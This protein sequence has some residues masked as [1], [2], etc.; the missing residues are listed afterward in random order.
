MAI[1]VEQ[2]FYGKDITLSNAFNALV[3]SSTNITEPKFKFVFDIYIDDVKQVRVR[4]SPNPSNR[5]VISLRE[6]LRSFVH[7]T[8]YNGANYIDDYAT[9]T[10]VNPND[11]TVRR[12][13]IEIFESYAPTADANPVIVGSATTIDDKA[14]MLGALQYS[15]GL[16]FDTDIYLM[17]SNARKGDFLTAA[18]EVE[19]NK[20]IY[21]TDEDTGVLAGLTF[22]PSYTTVQNFGTFHVDYYEADG[23]AL[24]ANTISVTGIQSDIATPSEVMRFYQCYPKNL[25]ELFT[26][27]LDPNNGANAGWKYYE[28]YIKNSADTQV[29][30][31]VVRFEK[32]N[33]T[34]FQNVRLRFLNNLGGWDYLNFTLN[35]Q[36][37]FNADRFDYK[38]LLG[39]YSDTLFSFGQSDRGD[40]ISNVETVER[41]QVQS[42]IYPEAYNSVFRELLSSREVY[43]MDGVI[44]RPVVIEDNSKQMI[45]RIDQEMIRYSFRIVYSNQILSA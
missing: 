28:V 2:N 8:K 3:V 7:P 29:L 11:N 13:K 39:N 4:R 20:T 34:P 14:V 12:L 19:G 36:Q 37:S 32:L 15:D 22:D 35:S 40:A 26:G 10:F 43:I 6:I 41:L 17:E 45:K 38:Q 33:C 1:T 44:P 18:Q 23:T 27:N 24:T 9:A 30:S 21:V 16:T 25:A 31:E 42:D 5:G